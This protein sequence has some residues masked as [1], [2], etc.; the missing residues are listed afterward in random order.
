VKRV[1]Y[2]NGTS[3]AE[4]RL[5]SYRYGSPGN[6]LL[7]VSLGLGVLAGGAAIAAIVVRRR[8]RKRANPMSPRE[9]RRSEVET[10]VETRS[11]SQPQKEGDRAR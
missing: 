8:R 6:A 2:A 1:A 4:L 9:R 11:S 5:Q 7:L 3:V 10:G